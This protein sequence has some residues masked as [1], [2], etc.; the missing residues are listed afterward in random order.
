M[1]LTVDASGINWNYGGSKIFDNGTLQI[2]TD[3]NVYINAS[4]II[5]RGQYLG[6]KLGSYLNT[7]QDK[8]FT[9]YTY[10]NYNTGQGVINGDPY[11][12]DANYSLITW[13]RIMCSAEIDVYSDKRIKKNICEIPKEFALN[14]IRN[15]VPC[16][17]NYK[18]VVKKGANLNYGFIAQEVDQI[19]PFVVKK[20][21]DFIPNVYEVATISENKITLTDFSTKD[22]L[23][24]DTNLKMK[25]FDNKDAEVI[26]TLKEIIDDKTFTIQENILEVSDNK[27]FVF[28]QEVDDMHSLEK[29]AIF[30]VTTAAVKYLD[31]ELQE[32]KSIVEKQQKVID[33]QTQQI[34]DLITTTEQLKKD[35]E[36]LQSKS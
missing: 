36:I 11:N 5:T 19:L 16:T 17:Y 28:G 33:I 20:T 10:L 24:Q 15:L 35:L 8:C 32:T 21:K 30:S 13:Y 7:E 23:T 12:P 27:I 14:T 29:N 2:T 9:K 1:T 31:I 3:D 4:V 25:M 26:V 34:Q 22:L 6:T 18:D